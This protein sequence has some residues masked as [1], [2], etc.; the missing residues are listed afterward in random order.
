MTNFIVEKKYE[1]IGLFLIPGPGMFILIIYF[2]FPYK[3]LKG[4]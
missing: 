2:P 1:K 4:V 3:L